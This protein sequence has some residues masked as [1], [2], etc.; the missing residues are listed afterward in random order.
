MFSRPQKT[1]ESN[2]MP[3]DN[4]PRIPPNLSPDCDLIC[5]RIS[6][7]IH[8]TYD[9]PIRVNF[10]VSHLPY[11]GGVEDLIALLLGIAA[12]ALK[13]AEHIGGACRMH[14]LSAALRGLARLSSTAPGKAALVSLK[15]IKTMLAVLQT[16]LQVRAIQ[17]L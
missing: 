3:A 13:G 15:G 11:L 17:I 16:E 8:G 9:D 12:E 2:M 14:S 1:K 4:Y 5:F 7:L 10:Q 6:T